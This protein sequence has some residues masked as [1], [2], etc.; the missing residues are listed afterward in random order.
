MLILVVQVDLQFPE[1]V[2]VQGQVA[3][4]YT[5]GHVV[6]TTQNLIWIDAAA[7]RLPGRSCVLPLPAVRAAGLRASHMLAQSK[8]CVE[9]SLDWQGRP[10]RTGRCRLRYAPDGCLSSP[11]S[12]LE[13]CTITLWAGRSNVHVCCIRQLERHACSGGARCGSG[14]ACCHPAVGLLLT[15]A[16]CSQV[17][18]QTRH[19]Q[20]L[21]DE[22]QKSLAQAPWRRQQ[23]RSPKRP[24]T[25]QVLSAA[26]QPLCITACQPPCHA[27]A[28]EMWPCCPYRPLFS[29]RTFRH[30]LKAHHWAC[31]HVTTSGREGK[32]GRWRAALF[33]FARLAQSNPKHFGHGAGDCGC[34]RPQR[35]CILT[36]AGRCGHPSA[37]PDSAGAAVNGLSTRQGCSGCTRNLQRRHGCHAVSLSYLTSGSESNADLHHNVRL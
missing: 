7:A 24:A 31:A 14:G 6:L 12:F 18:L 22:V 27:P 33:S 23:E 29:S 37:S 20:P 21:H 16:T 1:T 2:G 32:T 8:L 3:H 36:P 15:T 9:V 11:D 30:L 5:G 34:A 26:A 10:S 28:A 17:K 13:L 25:G 19:L 4:K 35:L